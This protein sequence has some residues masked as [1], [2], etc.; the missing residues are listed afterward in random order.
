MPVVLLFAALVSAV[1]PDAAPPRTRTL[2]LKPEAAAEDQEVARAVESLVAVT[3]ARIQ[4]L[5][6]LAAKDVTQM[7]ELEATRA[8][9]GCK[10]SE[11]CVA[12]LAGAIGAELVVFGDITRLGKLS[13]LTLN[14]FDSRAG[15]SLGRVSV[16][17]RDSEQL[18][19]ALP[20]ALV[21]IFGAAARDRGFDPT[22]MNPAPAAP[23]I[24]APPA[25]AAAGPPVVP[26]AIAGGG[27]VVAVAGA[28]GVFV[29]G[30]QW[31]AFS[32]A[33]NTANN[34]DLVTT[35]EE[36]AAAEQR[37][38]AAEKDY[39]GYGQLSLGVGASLVAV[40]LVGAVGGTV[41]ALMG[42]AP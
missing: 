3:V 22:P 16:Q 41:V 8:E 13:V 21:E 26:W 23:V 18:V 5:D 24:P 19:T 7:L 4:A 36:F 29:G 9:A 17:V 33:V 27:V 39:L 12:E 6:V 40:G 2:V 1:P 20:P 32:D 38:D 10:S 34:P 35:K 42:D 14:L 15:R 31:L 37:M 11:S 28:V 25:V 30:G